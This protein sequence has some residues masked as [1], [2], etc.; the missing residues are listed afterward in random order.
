MNGFF[1]VMASPAGRL[2]RIVSGLAL[3][4]AGAAVGGAGWIIAVIGVVP[5][6]AGAL[7]VCVF[8]PM[9]GRAFAGKALRSGR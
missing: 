1:S 5:L 6:V 3:I 9:F 2:T 7:D 8:A 4:V